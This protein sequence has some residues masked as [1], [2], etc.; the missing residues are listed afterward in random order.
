MI[1]TEF[2]KYYKVHGSIDLSKTNWEFNKY[3][4]KGRIVG[5]NNAE[6]IGVNITD[7]ESENMGLFAEISASATISN[8]KISGSINIENISASNSTPIYIGLLSGINKGTIENVFVELNGGSVKVIGD[9]YFGIGGVV[10][11]NQGEIKTIITENSTYTRLVNFKNYFEFVDKS[12]NDGNKL[13]LGGA[14]GVN[15]GIISRKVSEGLTEFNNN[16]ATAEVYI[17]AYYENT[18]P[19]SAQVGIGGI[20]GISHN[21]SNTVD[22]AGIY[23]VVAIGEIVAGKLTESTF[24]GHFDNV[25]GIVGDN[26]LA[27]Q[28]S[29]SKVYVRGRNSVGGAV[30]EN[31][32]EITAGNFGFGIKVEALEKSNN[33]NGF[34]ASFIIGEDNVG[35]I[36]GNQVQG[37]LK[38]SS[39]IS[40]IDRNFVS[41]IDDSSVDYLGDILIIESKSVTVNFGLI[42]GNVDELTEAGENKYIV[43]VGNIQFIDVNANYNTEQNPISI[44]KKSGAAG[45]ATFGMF[46]DQN[47]SEASEPPRLIKEGLFEN[48]K[49]GEYNDYFQ[50]YGALETL[51]EDNTG[52]EFIIM[53]PNEANIELGT[54]GKE[55][56]L[57]NEDNEDEESEELA[58]FL[59]YYK[60]E[61]N[62]YHD[63]T[64]N[65]NL[66]DIGNYISIGDLYGAS[67]KVV[68]GISLLEINAS[69]QFVVKGIGKVVLEITT[70]YNLNISK[71]VYVYIINYINNISAYRDSEYR[72]EIDNDSEIRFDATENTPIYFYFL[73][74]FNVYELTEATGVSVFAKV[75]IGDKT[76]IIKPDGEINENAKFGLIRESYNVYKIIVNK[77]VIDIP[78]S[79]EFI[80]YIEVSFGNLTFTNYL[81]EG[82]NS[83][84]IKTENDNVIDKINNTSGNLQLK[85][86]VKF[87]YK[88]VNLTKSISV[89]NNEISF[90]PYYEEEISVIFNSSDNNEKLTIR[91]EMLNA[92]GVVDTSFKPGW[93]KVVARWNGKV[94]EN[95]TNGDR[96]SIFSLDGINTTSSNLVSVLFQCGD[97]FKEFSEEQTFII[98]FISNNSKMATVRL[99]L[100]PQKQS[101][102]TTTLY[103]AK[104]PNDT[105][106]NF[107]GYFSYIPSNFMIPGQ[108]SLI[109]FNI[110]P[111]YTYYEF[112]E[113]TNIA[114]NEK[115]ILFDLF[116]RTTRNNTRCNKN[117]EWYKNS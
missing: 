92:N 98:T 49:Y 4:L 72:N 81:T 18:I 61:N 64:K 75:V 19:N 54:D 70:P 15:E 25:G 82:N 109:E 34:N 65:L 32:G 93:L 36:V 41:Q 84:I 9:Y 3:I 22:A 94:A 77:E 95:I 91:V 53:P 21:A 100:I 79:I 29:I 99:K 116:N 24:A 33:K 39:F 14:V 78:T 90:E 113:I 51:K 27:I 58:L 115:N 12:G 60:S 101:D 13:Y 102:I 76:Y 83:E 71:K 66:L 73:D 62:D 48:D 17:R 85:N 40:Y 37:D 87:K 67:I 74:R 38:S 86:K 68:E 10:G 35:G 20:S 55:N 110:V 5:E 23:G 50:R 44:S 1:Y 46:I 104:S 97:G 107:P 88:L 26:K 6:F 43:G 11:L 69:N 112:I 7:N 108:T 63:K 59:Y 30:G 2:A 106:F 105:H 117:R 96:K 56:R 57:Y 47:S 89:S 31:R 45:Y 28:G 114:S 16:F 80:P 103:D 111:S 42:F 8:I 52:F